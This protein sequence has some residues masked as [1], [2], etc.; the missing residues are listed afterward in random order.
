MALRMPATIQWTGAAF[1][2]EGDSKAADIEP[3]D[4]ITDNVG[5]MQSEYWD[6]LDAED[7]FKW[8][9]NNEPDLI[10]SEG[11]GEGTGEID[12]EDANRLRT[13]AASDD[14]KAV[15]AIADSKYGKDI[16]LGQDWYGE[17]N[18]H[19]KE[20]MDRFNA[21]VGTKKAA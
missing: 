1:D 17:M 16:L 18:L 20:T 19:D 14:P 4:Y 8:A 7:R 15:W 3:P 12:D 9:E 13:L 2:Q 11:G 6:Q 5:E 21:Y 10:S